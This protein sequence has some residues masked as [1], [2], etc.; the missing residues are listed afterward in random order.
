[1]YRSGLFSYIRN[2][3]FEFH[4]CSSA[5]LLDF[6][7]K[8]MHV[9]VRSEVSLRVAAHDNGHDDSGQLTITAAAN[10][11]TRVTL[12]V[13]KRISGILKNVA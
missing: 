1:M 9:N 3:Q 2:N 8:E 12:A 5:S 10:F 6:L 13:N 7:N 11:S 4:V